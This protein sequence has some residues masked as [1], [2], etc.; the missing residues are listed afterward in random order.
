MNI[1]TKEHLSSVKMNLQNRNNLSTSEHFQGSYPCVSSSFGY[2][3]SLFRNDSSDNKQYI[4][5]K[6]GRFFH[7]QGNH[8]ADEKLLFGRCNQRFFLNENRC[9]FAIKKNREFDFK[10]DLDYRQEF[11]RGTR[12]LACISL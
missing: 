8:F 9:L 12:L 11:L 4:L 1:I 3:F 7:T 5:F 6:Q 2:P 10:F